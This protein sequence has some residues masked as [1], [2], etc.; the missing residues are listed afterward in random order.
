MLFKNDVTHDVGA[1]K[2]S[3]GQ[4]AGIEADLHAMHDVFFRTKY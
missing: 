2:L 1:L 3:A 4:D